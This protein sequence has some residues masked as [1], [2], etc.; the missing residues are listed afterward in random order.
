MNKRKE[1]KVILLFNVGLFKMM[2]MVIIFIRVSTTYDVLFMTM[3]H[4]FYY[5]VILHNG[6]AGAWKA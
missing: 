5:L 3:T 6:S 2:N 4:G 1:I